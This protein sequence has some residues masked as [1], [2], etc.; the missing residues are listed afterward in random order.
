MEAPPILKPKI[1]EEPE[2]K[3]TKVSEYELNHENQKYNLTLSL[4]DSNYLLFNLKED[5]ITPIF[6]LNRSNLND[7][8]N[9]DKKL[10]IYDSELELYE[11]LN[12]LLK[13]GNWRK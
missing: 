8:S 12:D 11:A 4:T 3:T 5:G 13:Q 6:Y 2:E 9:I 10:G 1:T 7:L